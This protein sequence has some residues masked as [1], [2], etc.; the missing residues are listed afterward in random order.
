MAD[1]EYKI[2]VDASHLVYL[3]DIISSMCVGTHTRW[4]VLYRSGSGTVRGD[5]TSIARWTFDFISQADLNTLRV[6]VTTAAVYLPSKTMAIKTRLDNGTF[7]VFD[8]QMEWPETEDLEDSRM[9]GSGGMFKDVT[10]TFTQLRL[11]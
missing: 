11:Y 9:P 10:I 4:P 1:Y 6:Y 2:G 7:A 8:C 3:E 5:G